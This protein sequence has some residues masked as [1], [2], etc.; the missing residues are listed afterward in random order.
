MRKGA[1][2]LPDP[3]AVVAA[4]PSIIRAVATRIS[5]DPTVVRFVEFMIPF[6]LEDRDKEGGRIVAEAG[7][8]GLCSSES[9]FFCRVSELPLIVNK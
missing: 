3:P 5:L 4:A 9:N 8:A 2:T 6:L 1:G 7:G